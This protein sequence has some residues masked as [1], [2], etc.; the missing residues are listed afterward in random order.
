MTK[1][2][3]SHSPLASVATLLSGLLLTTIGHAEPGISNSF[4]PY[5]WAFA[6]FLSFFLSW[7]VVYL[8]VRFGRLESTLKRWLTG[9]ILLIIFLITVT[10]YVAILGSIMI[11][12][13]TM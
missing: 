9:I 2:I 5:V 12:G 1:H 6:V 11:A 7:L 10:P 13:R 4:Q 3:K 8:L